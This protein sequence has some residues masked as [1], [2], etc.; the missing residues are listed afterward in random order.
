MSLVLS[1]APSVQESSTAM[2]ISLRVSRFLQTR[3]NLFP[4]EAYMPLAYTRH[5]I[6]MKHPNATAR[7][8]NSADESQEEGYRR[9]VAEF[10][11]AAELSQERL[12]AECGFERT[13]LSRVERGILNPTAIRVWA[14]A[15]ALRVPLHELAHRMEKW[16]AERQRE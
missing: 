4:N 7:T 13:Y 2:M 8:P 9:G 10:R 1:F 14:I 16:I 5:N 11:K 12:S 6:T 3:L 15:D